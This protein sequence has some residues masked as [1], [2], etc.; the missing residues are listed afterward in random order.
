MSI[1]AAQVEDYVRTQVHYK[2]E[3]EFYVLW[4]DSYRVRI[5]VLYLAVNSDRDNALAGYPRMINGNPYIDVQVSDHADLDA[6]D[7]FLFTEVALI[8][9]HEAREFWRSGAGRWA[10]YHPHRDAEN[11]RFNRTKLG[12]VLKAAGFRTSGIR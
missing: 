8:E 9:V 11:A 6:L 7:E 4:A 10:R 1:T 3:W 12:R 2:P 5:Q